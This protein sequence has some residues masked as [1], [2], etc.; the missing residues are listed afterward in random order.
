MQ[1]VIVEVASNP[2]SLYPY[3]SFSLLKGRLQSSV[4]IGIDISHLAMVV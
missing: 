3:V 2:F 1:D 4:L